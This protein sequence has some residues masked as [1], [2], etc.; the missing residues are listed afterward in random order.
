MITY[1]LNRKNNL[2]R[3]GMC[4]IE[5]VRGREHKTKNKYIKR[6]K[7]KFLIN[8]SILNELE[9]KIFSPFPKNMVTTYEYATYLDLTQLNPSNGDVHSLT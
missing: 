1:K 4:K 2:S 3:F 9:K 7:I 5:N 8:Y 6:Y